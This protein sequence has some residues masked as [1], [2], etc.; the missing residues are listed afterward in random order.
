MAASLRVPGARPLP[1]DGDAAYRLGLARVITGL[2][3]RRT[4]ARDRLRRASSA[5][6]Q[7]AAAGAIA[8]AYEAAAAELETL[9]SRERP[10][11]PTEMCAELAQAYRRLSVAATGGDLA[12][13]RSGRAEVQSLE[14]ELARALSRYSGAS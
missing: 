4:P 11:E 9:Q 8:A 10:H 2:N 1:L 14:E 12:R 3:E 6:G 5:S 13:W 7:G